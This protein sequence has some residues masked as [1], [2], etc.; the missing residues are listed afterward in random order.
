MNRVSCIGI[1]ASILFTFGLAGALTGCT[2][3]AESEWVLSGEPLPETGSSRA[4]LTGTHKLCSAIMAG[5]WR[6]TILVPNAWNSGMCVSFMRSIGA[7]HAQL[8]CVTDTGFSW[9]TTSGVSPGLPPT[10][11]GW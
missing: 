2:S 11:C 7:L 5:D 8:G 4:A 10:N 6:D 3:S 9:G 1:I